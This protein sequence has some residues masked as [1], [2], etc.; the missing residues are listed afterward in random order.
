MELKTYFAQD[1][2][3]N[4]ISSAIVKVFLQGT[5]TLATGLTRADGT[6]LENPF[7]A[8]GAGRIQFRAPDGY[9][10]VQVSAGPG[11]IQ[12]LTIQCV[13]YS[14]VK[15]DAERAEAA[16]DRADVSSEQVA[17][18]V[19][20][21]G[22]LAD[23]SKGDSLLT[24]QAPFSDSVP[25]TQHSKNADVLH[26]KDFGAAG[27]YDTD[28]SDAIEKW[29]SA[30]S[31]T[32]KAGDAG[33]GVYRH[34]RS[35][36]LPAGVVIYGSGSPKIAHFPQYGGDKSKLRPGYKHLINGAVFIFSGTATKTYT[37]NRS[38]R[39]SSFTYV[40]R[41][42]EYAGF[43]ISGVAF[44]LDCDVY[45]AAGELTTKATDNRAIAG[46]LFVNNGTLGSFHDVTIFG[47]TENAA[48]VCHNQAGGTTFDADYISFS[49]NSMI[50]GGVAIIGHDTAAGPST[51]GITG[52]RFVDT[53]IYGGDHHNR[54]DGDFTRGAIYID[55][56]MG[57][58]EQNGIRAHSFTAC[59]IRTYANDA[60]VTDH[61]NDISFVN[62]TYEFPVLAGVTGADIA[63]GFVG[64]ANTKR[65][66]SFGAGASD[67]ARMV[68]YLQS[69]TGP[70]QVI[71]AGELDTAVFGHTGKFVR[72]N[73]DSANA[74]IQFGDDLG[75][76]VADWRIM[77]QQSTDFLSFYHGSDERLSLHKDGGVQ[78]NFGFRFGGT[79][80]IASGAITVGSSGF[81]GVLGEGSVAD[82]LTTI[83]GGLY[84]GQVIIFRSVLA[85]SPI[86][87]K[88][89]IGNLRLVSD[90][91]LSSSQDR[92]TLQ[93]DGLNWIEL[94]YADNS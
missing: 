80:T 72:L 90:R 59:N 64:T 71:G 31:A 65:F 43:D 46:S 14:G 17:D 92:I 41:A 83:N 53:G 28:D 89:G 76:T 88:D 35:F 38:D 86:T 32:G 5:T 68:S 20:L 45:N 87:F 79:R 26:L 78:G 56:N 73:A 69:I 34:T 66:R 81:Y 2:A 74:I 70:W 52:N 30:L 82:D 93:W 84:D 75:T 42:P 39:Y 9:Y 60:I 37:T 48:Y 27:D 18:A 4:I 25:R 91:V 47:Y 62:N 67:G 85:A 50:S 22:E 16:A 51:E 19:A 94:S 23:P 77:W 1:A 15:A 8:D 11:I 61:C 54:P 3:G 55:G 13:D 36:D 24:T 33:D 40:W 21:R 12:T 6:P 29:L 63:G 10:D 7:A 58:G 49:G 44:I 57:T